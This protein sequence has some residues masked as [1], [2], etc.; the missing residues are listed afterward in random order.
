MTLLRPRLVAGLVVF[1]LIV[2]SGAALADRACFTWHA[3][4]NGRIN[5]D[6][7]ASS[8]T[9]PGLIYWYFWSFGDGTDGDLT[10]STTT[11]HTFAA[12][13]PY[14]STVGLSVTFYPSFN[15]VSVSCYVWPWVLPVGPQ[16][17]TTGTCCS[18]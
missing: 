9:P 16:P 11:S 10:T 18:P 8:A 6:S 17:P 4:G 7:S 13:P 1:G 2:T 12:P 5:F 14:D 15:T 3:V